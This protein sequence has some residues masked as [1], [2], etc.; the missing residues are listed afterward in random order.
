M[1]AFLVSGLFHEWMVLVLMG[2]STHWENLIFFLMQGV[3]TAMEVYL[4]QLWKSAFGYDPIKTAPQW[5]STPITLLLFLAMSPLFL[6]PYVR[7]DIL[8][9]LRVPLVT[10]FYGAIA[11][12]V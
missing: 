1:S 12:F 8:L 11:Q 9:L 4:V 3:I 10:D 7:E 2:R 5:I 6:N